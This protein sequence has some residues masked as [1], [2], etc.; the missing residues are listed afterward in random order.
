MGHLEPVFSDKPIDDETVA[1]F[2]SFVVS[3]LEGLSWDVTVDVVEN[4]IFHNGFHAGPRWGS[5]CS[6]A[7]GG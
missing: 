7:R 6:M 3:V 2:L 5:V 4:T 1:R